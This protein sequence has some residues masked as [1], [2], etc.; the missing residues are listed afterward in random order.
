MPAEWAPHRATWLAWPHQSKDWPGKFGAIP[1]TFAEIVRHLS[2]AE[3]VQLL[4]ENRVLEE[5]A[6]RILQRVGVDLKRVKLHRVG[7]DRSWLRDSAP[8]FV[9]AK[10]GERRA[11]CWRFNAWA[12][13]DNWKKDVKVSQAVAR[14]AGV[15][16]LAP[17][18]N[19]GRVVM[20]GGA[21]DVDGEGTLLGTEECLLSDVQARNPGLGRQGIEAVFREHLGVE[22][23]LWLGQGIAGDDTHGHIDDLCRFVSPGRVLLCTESNRADENYRGLAENHER[24]ERA[25]DAKGRGIEVISLPMPAPLYFEGQRLPASY[26]NF[27]IANGL[28]LVPTFNDPKDREAL[29]ILAECFPGRRVVGIHAVDLVWGFGTLHCLSQQEPDAV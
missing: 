21:V 8:T 24:L 1:W 18:A 3:P 17:E 12:K 5:K 28:I 23:V 25:R 6:L 10:G 9:V 7:T 4:V 19:G 29:G 2:V 20:E 16:A 14:L 11:V 26:A 15:P 27:Y 13:Y 22:K